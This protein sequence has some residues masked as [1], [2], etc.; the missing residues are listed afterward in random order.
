MQEY[1]E[2]LNKQEEQEYKKLKEKE[3]ARRNELMKYYQEI[4]NLPDKISIN[5]ELIINNWGQPLNQS[6]PHKE[7]NNI[8]EKI[9]TVENMKLII[10][11]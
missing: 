8:L 9:Q 10:A 4:L 1:L 6:N 7:A 2:Q 3:N 11:L 5:K